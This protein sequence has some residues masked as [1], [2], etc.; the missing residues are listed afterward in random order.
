VANIGITILC[1]LIIAAGVV[2]VFIPGIPGLLLSWFGVLLW[3]LLGAGGPARWGFLVV[4]TAVALVG[5]GIKYTLPGRGLK[6][7]G[8]GG[9]SIVLGALFGIPLFFLIPVIGLPIGF[10]LGVMLG[11]LIRHPGSGHAFRSTLA[12]LKAV[13]LAVMIEI[14][15]A[16]AVAVVWVIAVFVT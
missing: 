4:A 15:T 9:L 10:V 14:A 12:A 7:S 8:V 13:G 1:G 2:G 6:A 11:E 16:M 3:C 5:G